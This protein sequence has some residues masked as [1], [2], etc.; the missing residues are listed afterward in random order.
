MIRSL[1]TKSFGQ[2]AT[3][4]FYDFVTFYIFIY[5]NRVRPHLIDTLRLSIQMH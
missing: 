1:H 5:L 3:I 2:S 4:E